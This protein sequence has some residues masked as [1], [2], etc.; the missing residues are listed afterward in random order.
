MATN[1]IGN[2][3]F[4]GYVSYLAK[5]DPNSINRQGYSNLLGIIGNDGGINFTNFKGLDTPFGY[6]VGANGGQR[7][8]SDVNALYKKYMDS[9]KADLAS[10]AN[11]SNNAYA[12]AIAA[13]NAQPKL[14][15]FDYSGSMARAG[16]TAASTVN[17]V[18]QDKLNQYLAKAQAALGQKQVDVSRNKEDIA[19]ALASALEDSA[20]SRTRATE[21][22]TT[23]LGDITDNENSWQRQE[24][25]QFDAARMAL[26]GDTANAGLTESGIGQQQEANAVTDRNLAS[27]DQTR[28]FNNQRRDVNTVASRTLADLDTSDTR[29]RAGSQRATEN[30]DIDLN[31]FIQNASLDEQSFRASNEAERVS[32]INSATQSAYQNIVAQTIQALTGQG[33]RAQDIALFKQVYG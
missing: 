4:R 23:Q 30:Q 5:N 14:P 7:L 2:N 13:L 12:A 10:T 32:A 21:D 27:E 33:A 16:Q 11:S 24:G 22:Q 17:P 18:Y 8:Q 15:K 20:T 31:N 26:L 1:Y 29:E 9:Y 19:T 28:T 6:S 25:R 3:D